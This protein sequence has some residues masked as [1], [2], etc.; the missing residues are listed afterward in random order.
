LSSNFQ[1]LPPIYSGETY[2]CYFDNQESPTIVYD[3]G[4]IRC[5]TPTSGLP[6]ITSDTGNMY[7]MQRIAI[8]SGSE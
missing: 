7:N 5:T 1:S 3:N 8:G 4:T 2:K 6:P